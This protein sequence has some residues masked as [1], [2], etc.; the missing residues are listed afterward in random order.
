MELTGLAA[1]D[2]L[3]AQDR[4]DLLGALNGCVVGG[5][6]V[7]A[8]IIAAP[9]AG[10]AWFGCRGGS[11]FAIDMVDG[12]M[13]RLDAEDTGA[14][15]AALERAEPLLR[16]IETAL[17]IELE[18]EV[19]DPQAPPDGMRM[20]R[21]MLHPGVTLLHLALPRDLI[22]T[23]VPAPFAPDLLGRVPLEITLC[24]AGPRLGPMDAADLGPGDLVLLGAGPLAATLAVPGR[25]PVAGRF[26]P[27]ARRFTPSQQEPGQ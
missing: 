4:M 3:D 1:I 10:L 5:N 15:V 13:L 19:L 16:A 24:L 21:V 6:T 22:L 23:P 9:P 14:A 25:A 7:R 27:A 26:D 17:G 20:L 12:A 11:A 18:P 8:A 2:P